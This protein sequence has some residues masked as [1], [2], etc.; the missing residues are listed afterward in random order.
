MSKYNREQR[1]SV[2]QNMVITNTEYKTLTNP[3]PAFV[4]YL[5]LMEKNL[6]L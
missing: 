2:T 6:I 5:F 1:V 4:V 3:K